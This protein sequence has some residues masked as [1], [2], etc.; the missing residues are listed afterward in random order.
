MNDVAVHVEGYYQLVTGQAR[1]KSNF[2]EIEFVIEEHDCIFCFV[3][4]NK[5][6]ISHVLLGFFFNDDRSFIVDG[7]WGYCESSRF[8]RDG[9]WPCDP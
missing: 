3:L 5:S 8:C 1:Y 4:N 7:L 9:K 6:I 2:M